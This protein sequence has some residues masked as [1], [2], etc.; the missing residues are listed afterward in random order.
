MENGKKL[1]QVPMVVLSALAVYA[2]ALKPANADGVLDELTLRDAILHAIDQKVNQQA[3]D[4]FILSRVGRNSSNKLQALL[5]ALAVSTG[6]DVCMLSSS[7]YKAEKAGSGEFFTTLKQRAY[8]AILKAQIASALPINK[9][10]IDKS[11]ANARVDVVK[12]F[13]QNRGQIFDRA[14]ISV[15]I[16]NINYSR[17][18]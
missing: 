7:Y 16:G 15:G 6:S 17:L 13:D 14:K 11:A 1:W 4:V 12:C 2:L 9:K 10:D 3:G 18:D 5:N 8:K